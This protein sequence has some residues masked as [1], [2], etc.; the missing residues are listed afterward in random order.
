MTIEELK[1]IDNGLHQFDAKDKILIDKRGYFLYY[2]EPNRATKDVNIHVHFCGFCAW[3][4]GTNRDSEPGRNGV[5]IGPFSEIEQAQTFAE[6]V[7][8]ELNYTTHS[9]CER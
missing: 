9:C 4:A 5:W 8:N 2:N 1:E 3:G 6:N 7:L